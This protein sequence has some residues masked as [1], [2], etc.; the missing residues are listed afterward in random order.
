[1]LL[2]CLFER[3]Q[4]FKKLY[5]DKAVRYGMEGLTRKGKH[6]AGTRGERNVLT[7]ESPP[8]II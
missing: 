8:E 7:F 1:M 4:L 3:F 6:S 5:L 2:L